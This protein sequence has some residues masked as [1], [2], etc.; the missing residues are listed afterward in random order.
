MGQRETKSLAGEGTRPARASAAQGSSAVCLGF[1]KARLSWQSPE[2][3][4][5]RE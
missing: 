5:V 1:R 3:S 2:V 4:V